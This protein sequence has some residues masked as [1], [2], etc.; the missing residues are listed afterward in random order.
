MREHGLP[1]IIH[2]RK[3]NL[4]AAKGWLQSGFVVYVHPLAYLLGMEGIALL[5]SCAGD[6][7]EID[8]RE[9]A[10][11]R[12]AEIR[13]LVSDETLAAAGV[14]MPTVDSV[15][16]YGVW[17]RTYDEPGNGAFPFEEPYIRAITDTLPQSSIL[18]AACGTG[19][20]AEHLAAQGH[21]VIGVDSSPEMLAL[22]RKRVPSADFREGV[23]EQL[24]VDDD[25]VDGV[26]CS[27]AL[28]HVRELEP[29][30]AEFARVL[31]PGGHLV[32]CDMHSSSV[33]LGSIPKV[34]RD[35]GTPGR[36]ATHRHRT[37]DYLRAALPHGF[38]ARGCDE[39]LIGEGSMMPAARDA[40]AEM[41]PGDWQD[42][43]W[44]LG[45]LVPQAAWAANVGRPATVIWHFQLS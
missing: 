16:G 4:I 42:W 23:L 31:R 25:E 35:D 6:F 5:R 45:D 2:R 19:R 11:A 22:A 41:A 32:I 10:A 27:L 30:M 20:H 34:I 44:N 3:S 24:P 29:V 7:D 36:I 14:S 43:P 1:S 38:Q 26:V 37:G 39:P 18:D 13:R 21:R 28:T 33:L 40:D 15:E 12:L 17:S 9:F 8:G